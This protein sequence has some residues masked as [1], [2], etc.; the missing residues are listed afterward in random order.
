VFQVASN[1]RCTILK[2]KK[3]STLNV[4]KMLQSFKGVHIE[5]PKGSSN[6]QSGFI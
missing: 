6:I 3:G 2:K 4:L 5:L 1:V